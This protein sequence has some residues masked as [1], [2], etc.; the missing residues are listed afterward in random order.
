MW[1]LGL[2]HRTAPIELRERAALNDEAATALLRELIASPTIAEAMVVSTCN[3]MELYFVAA[4]QRTNVSEEASFRLENGEISDELAVEVVLEA[5]KLSSNDVGKH[6]YLYS[7]RSAV[8]HLFRVA[9]SLDSLVVGEPQILGQL[10][11]GFERARALGA[12]G[13][14]LNRAAMRAFRTAKRIRSETTI[15]TGQVSIATVALDL[16]RQIFD[17]LEQRTVVLVGTGE[18]GETIARLFQQ[19]GAKL[20]LVGRNEQRVMTLAKHVGSE[21]RLMNELERTLEEACVVVTSTSSTLPVISYEQVRSVMRRRRGRELF[22]VDVA[23]PRDVE[24][25]VGTIDGVY[26]YNVDDLSSVVTGTQTNRLEGAQQAE[27]IVEEELREYER[28]EEVEQVTPTLRAL[29]AWF[30]K[31][32]HAEVERSSLG[33]LR[34][35]SEAERRTLEC[36]VDAATKKLLHHSATT[37]KQWA[38]ERPEELQSTLEIVRALFLP[39]EIEQLTTS[40]EGES[41]VSIQSDGELESCRCFVNAGT[42]TVSAEAK[43][44]IGTESSKTVVPALKI[45]EN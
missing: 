14:T 19:A 30:S 20:V 13:S 5:L 2:S 22:F 43:T 3:R 41:S 6:V 39:R 42:K 12:I 21:G 33:K 1:V 23:V 11:R 31:V 4:Q 26:L 35:L 27:A 15:G 7:D 36:L 18:M 16:A 28:R 29:Y 37:L 9:A 24:E 45:E 40:G 32:I 10:K 17:Q 25:K 8:M 38:I 44:P 34:N